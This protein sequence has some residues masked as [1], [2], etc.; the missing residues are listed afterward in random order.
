MMWRVVLFVFVVAFAVFVQAVAGFG[1]NLLAMPIGIVLVGVGVS[2]PV[3]TIIAWVT[4]VT[5]AIS[6]LKNV[7]KK[8]LL[9][10]VAVMFAGI[11]AG[12]WLFGNVSLDFLLIIYAVVVILIG[13]KKLFFESTKTLPEP[14]QWGALGIAGIMQGLFVSGGSFLVV[15]A[16]AKIREKQVFRSTINAVWALLNIFLIG[17][18]L[19]DGTMTAEVW[20]VTGA[21]LI[22]SFLAIY[23]GG[24]VAKKI[25]QK[26]FLKVAYVILIASG[27]VLLVTNL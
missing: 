2:K 24:V 7:H 1:G 22:P 17:T 6:G 16:V 10:M 27:T 13:I 25:N 14:L 20:K 23:A 21:C 15:Y 4:G 11:L 26:V 9:K 19:V 12:L 18:Y 8:E 5:V 3:M